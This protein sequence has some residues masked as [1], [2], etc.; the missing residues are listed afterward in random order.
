MSFKE[1]LLTKIKIDR[2]AAKVM[3]SMGPAEG[4]SK[5]DKEAMRQLLEMSP[6]VHQKERDLDLYVEPIAGEQKKILVLDNELPIYLTTIEDVTI[7]KSPLIKEMVKIRN[8]IK[9][10]K[11]SDVKI[12]RKDESVETIRQEC[13]DPL[14]LSF[15]ASDIAEIARDG[16]AS[17][18]RDYPDGVIES[19][20]L[21]AELLDYKPAPRAF[22]LSR[23]IILGTLSTKAGG[24]VLYGPMVIYSQIHGTLKLIDEQI[25]S[26]DKPKLELIQQIAT[27]K[28]KAAVEGADVFEYLKNAVLKKNQT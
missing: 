19:L 24:E 14:D 17:L 11:D 28:Q 13:I 5:V 27:D 21:F 2:L 7:R 26:F 3:A 10:L 8:M 22:Q 16:Q 20:E 18:E 9:I 23:H 6:Y 15:N 1:N 25:G 12:S 4:G